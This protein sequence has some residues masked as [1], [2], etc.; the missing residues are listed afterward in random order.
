MG[1][2]GGRGSGWYRYMEQLANPEAAR[3]AHEEAQREARRRAKQEREREAEQAERARER[4]EWREERRGEHGDR[5]EKRAPP[6]EPGH[7]A[8]GAAAGGAGAR[9]W[10][11]EDMASMRTRTW[12]EY[13]A[14]FDVWRERA[15]REISV[16]VAA[17]PLPPAGHAPVAPAST[18]A[19]WH[20][21]VKKATLRWHPDKWSR[22]ER[23]VADEAE[24][25]A[26]KQLTQAMFRAVTRHKERGWRHA[27]ATAGI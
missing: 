11:R 25:E 23:M 4:D 20:V 26:L 8:G 3:E 14:A 22:L 5:G 24:R 27:R 1:R 13:D 18:E 15:A 2:G 9:R 17:I 12:D 16:T 10:R 6:P 19:A 21:A 7:A